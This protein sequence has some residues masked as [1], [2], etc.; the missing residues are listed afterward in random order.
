MRTMDRILEIEICLNYLNSLMAKSVAF[1]DVSACDELSALRR[2]I[3]YGAFDY[4]AI[5]Q[6][7]KD[8]DEK[9][10]KYE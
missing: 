6:S 9:L 10:K 2:Q 1:H 8:L 4:H 5:F 3:Y 7:L